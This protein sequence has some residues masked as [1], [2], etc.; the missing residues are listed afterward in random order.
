[1]WALQVALTHE[2]PSTQS[3]VSLDDLWNKKLQ[4][5]TFTRTL[6]GN[7]C[8]AKGRE[9]G[10]QREPARSGWAAFSSWGALGLTLKA[11]FS[12]SYYTQI[13]LQLHSSCTTSLPD[14]YFFQKHPCPPTLCNQRLIQ[15]KFR[16]SIPI[17]RKLHK[18]AEPNKAHISNK[19]TNKKLQ[20]KRERERER[21]DTRERFSST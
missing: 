7:E 6:R 16:K 2:N 5:F 19:Q 17:R 18:K 4:P 13:S 3:T 20:C 1:M 9:G 11:I 21:R 14:P 15:A 10:R 8:C 12:S